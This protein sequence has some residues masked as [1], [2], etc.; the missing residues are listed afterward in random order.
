MNTLKRL[1]PIIL[2]A[3]VALA[4]TGDTGSKLSTEGKVL[5]TIKSGL[6]ATDYHST[7]SGFAKCG[8]R[9]GSEANPMARNS[10]GGFSSGKFSVWNGIDMFGNY[11][12]DRW[13]KP[14]LP[15]WGQWLMRIPIYGG[16]VVWRG[17][18][19]GRNY[20]RAARIGGIQ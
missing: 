16:G 5:L 1:L 11:S 8:S 14:K 12:Y 20:Q 10:T 3:V 4:Q 2:L 19:V 13:L 7:Q 18:I 17:Y 6:I 15:P 9:C